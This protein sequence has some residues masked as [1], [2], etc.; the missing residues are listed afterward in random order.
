VYLAQAGTGV[1]EPLTGPASYYRFPERT[2]VINPFFNGV[3]TFI[4]QVYMSQRLRDRP[5]VNTNWVM[6]LNQ[7][8]EL[9][10]EDVNLDSLTDIRVYVYYTD[11]TVL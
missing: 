3:R 11:F 6:V 2:A 5:F 10:N 9:A 8:D 4:P 7:L 1:V